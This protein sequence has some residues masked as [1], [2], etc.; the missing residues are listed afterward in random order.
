MI[1]VTYCSH[2]V[3]SLHIHLT[4]EP[5]ETNQQM[6]RFGQLGH[7]LG[8]QFDLLGGH[9]DTLG[10]GLNRCFIG[11]G[12]LHNSYNTCRILQPV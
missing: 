5:R 9:L 4:I 6:N 10:Q 2:I 3:V 7:G 1:L 12:G 8:D 11:N